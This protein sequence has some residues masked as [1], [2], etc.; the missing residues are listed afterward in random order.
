MWLFNSSIGKKFIMAL[1][2]AALVLFVTFHVLMN[3]V[4]ICWP[5]A[6]NAVCQ[7]L[8]ANWYALIASAGLGLLVVIHIIYALVLT[9]QNR[10]ARGNDRYAVT[11]RP[12]S[13]E[14]SSKNMLVLGIVVVA[15]LGVHLVQFWARMQLE[16]IM[17][18]TFDANGVEV[19]GAAGTIYLQLAF[20]E[21][22]TLPVY[23]IGF[24]AL[25]FHMTHG[26]WS[27]WQTIGW[28]ND[29][30]MPR[31]KCIGNWWVTIVCGL[32]AIQ[33]VVFTVQ[34]N[35]N[36]YLTDDALMS[37]YYE[38]YMEHAEKV[39]EPVVAEALA[40]QAKLVNAQ[41]GNIPGQDLTDMM[42]L[43]GKLQELNQKMQ[44]NAQ[45]AQDAFLNLSKLG[46][47]ST[48]CSAAEAPAK[49]DPFK[50]AEPAAQPAAPEAEGATEE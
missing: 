19:P 18:T 12:K 42:A 46:K 6:Y 16:E 29:K 49:E 26:F 33:A 45:A 34:A 43:Q 25:W 35:K 50:A 10:N 32:F 3:A 21:C 39:N 13:V 27:M 11:S 41:Q 4:A 22:W 8:G 31:L 20:Q 24:V 15:F 47:C 2:G 5:T 30:W 23:L 17:G 28:D 9:I 44:E 48:S 37:Q 7:F 14:W 1:T 38:M 40:I 36:F